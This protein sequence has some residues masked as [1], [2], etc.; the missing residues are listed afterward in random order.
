MNKQSFIVIVCVWLWFGAALAEMPPVPVPAEN[1]ITEEKRVLGKILFWD[2]QLSSDNTIACGTCHQFGQAGA[3]GR[4]SGHPGLD[5]VPGTADDKIGSP[6]VVSMN[7]GGEYVLHSVF[8]LDVQVTERSANPT[9]GA[10]YAPEMFWDGR[11]GSQFLDPETGVV[12]IVSG[13]ALENQAVGPILSDV[14]MAKVGRTWPEVTSK[15]QGV[16]PLVFATDLPDDVSAALALNGDYPS[17]FQAAFGDSQITAERIGFAI[18]TYERTLIADETPWDHFTEGDPTAMTPA[19]IDGWNI[20][21]ASDCSVCHSPPV[22]S[23]QTF[24]NVAVRPIAEDNGRQEVTGNPADR[25]RFKTPT[26]RNVGLKNTYFHNGILTDVDAV[27]RHY[28]DPN[29]F[30]EN[31]DPLLPVPIP[32]GDRLNLVDFL[33]NGLTDPRV[34]N[35]EFP[36]DQPTL[37]AG[38]NPFFSMRFAG[39]KETLSWNAVADAQSYPMYRGLLSNL[40]DGNG[41]SVPDGGYGD[42]VSDL[43]GNLADLEFTDIATPPPGDGFFYSRGFVN[44]FGDAGGLGLSSRGV[45]RMDEVA[46]TCP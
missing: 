25:G 33:T 11:A 35:R 8:D 21:Q 13:G 23:D 12:S 9:V 2:E 19:Q 36:F 10:A 46:M 17:L 15:L 43:D 28:N 30:V 37:H 22:F 40:V 29:R 5:G 6:G 16:V 42:C 14:E 44:G 38:D 45:S 20:F 34:A 7:A 27:I 39:D 24:R 26:L 4:K 31:E 18:A 41:D 1:P 3:D 32:P